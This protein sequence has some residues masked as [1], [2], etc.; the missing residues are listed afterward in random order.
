[1]VRLFEGQQIKDMVKIP[2]FH[3]VKLIGLNERAKKIIKYYQNNLF[4][5]EF[6]ELGKPL[7]LFDNK[8]A[9]FCVSPDGFWSG[10]FILDEDIRFESEYKNLVNTLKKSGLLED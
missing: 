1:V 8:S 7:N 10:W 4:L 3:P 5:Q 6:D 2:K 9:I